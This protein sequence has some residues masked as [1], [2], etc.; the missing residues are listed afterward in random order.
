MI[1]TIQILFTVAVIIIG[2][3]DTMAIEEAEYKVVEKEDRFEIRD[4]VPHI[5]AETI[6][7]S[8]IEKA[9]RAARCDGNESLHG[10]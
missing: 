2:A 8:D 7:E 4:Y 10:V 1:R 6:V 5:L 9:G 3:T